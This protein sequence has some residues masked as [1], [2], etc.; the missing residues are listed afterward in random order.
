MRDTFQIN[1]ENNSPTPALK[2]FIELFF[3]SLWLKFSIK[4]SNK[5]KVVA[6]QGT[7]FVDDARTANFVVRVTRE[8]AFLAPSHARASFGKSI[9]PKAI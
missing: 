9:L 6:G 2:T 7:Y 3:F 8:R 5:E 4:V 1:G